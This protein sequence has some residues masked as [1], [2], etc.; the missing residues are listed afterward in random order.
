MKNYGVIWFE[1]GMGSR[2]INADYQR[3]YLKAYTKNKNIKYIIYVREKI[4]CPNVGRCLMQ[5]EKLES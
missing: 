4:T 5:D 1:I 2:L 3:Y